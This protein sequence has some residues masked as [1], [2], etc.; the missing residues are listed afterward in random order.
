MDAARLRAAFPVCA[1]RA[2]LNSGTDGPVPA[3][4]VAAARAELDDELASG[5]HREHFERRQELRAELRARYAVR[6]GARPE[7]VAV[8]SS[9]SE[10]IARA[11]NGLELRAG[12]LIVTSTDEHPGLLGPLAAARDRRGV[13]V[14]AVPWDELPDA[15]DPRAVL[16]ACSHV[17]WVDGRVVPDALAERCREAEVLLLLD[18]AQGVGAVPVDVEVLG[19]S[20]YAGSGQKWLCGPDGAGMLW[21]E[22]SVR[23]AVD[24]P[25]PNYLSMA[26]PHDPLSGKLHDD[27]R[28]YDGASLSREANAFAIAAHDVLDEFGFEA[29]HAR[30][31]ELAGT[32]ARELAARGHDV[33]PRGETTL[34]SWRV[35]GDAEAQRNR[36]VDDGIVIRDLPGR[37]LLRASVGAWNDASD[38]ERLLEAL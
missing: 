35:D 23:D 26:D 21:I 31:R 8:T 25:E 2:Y 5:R 32:L 14:R 17:N 3:A 6:L 9:T 36:L 13:E 19:C 29:V 27:A 7:D 12:D 22:P 1:S 15:A 16:V 37:G 28:R 10:G 24:M 11:L 30:A 38:L 20:I 4:A 34:V 33:A 18:G